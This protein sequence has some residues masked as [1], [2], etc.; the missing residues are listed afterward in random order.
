[1]KSSIFANP[2]LSKLGFNPAV[3]TRKQDCSLLHFKGQHPIL[4]KD[5]GVAKLATGLEKIYISKGLR[6]NLQL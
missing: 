4:E 5:S 2:P 6:N 1:M 3:E